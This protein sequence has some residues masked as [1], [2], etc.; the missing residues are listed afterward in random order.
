MCLTLKNKIKII[1]CIPPRVPRTGYGDAVGLLRRVARLA[2]TDKSVASS[3]FIGRPK[4][5]NQ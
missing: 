4:I 1:K 5:I 2:T 3:I